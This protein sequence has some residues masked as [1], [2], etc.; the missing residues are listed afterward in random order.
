MRVSLLSE[1][2]QAVQGQSLC[3]RDNQRI[4]AGVKDAPLWGAEDL[5]RAFAV[6]IRTIR[7]AEL[8]AE[9]TSAKAE[10]ILRGEHKARAF[11][12]ERKLQAPQADL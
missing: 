5:A 4:F 3:P 8:T 9:E 11:A 7:R 10:A 6:G 2:A 1:S 12:F